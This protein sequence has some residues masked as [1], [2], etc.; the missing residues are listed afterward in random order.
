M[1]T[2][3]IKITFSL[4]ATS[5][6]LVVFLLIIAPE[7][8]GE[9]VSISGT[10]KNH[11]TKSAV[12][13]ALVSLVG[14]TLSTLTD[15]DG[16]FF[17]GT[18]VGV[19][20]RHLKR[21]STTVNS[22][23]GGIVFAVPS[24]AFISLSIFSFDG[25]H[26]FSM[27][28]SGLKTGSWVVSPSL[29]AGMYVCRAQVNRTIS[30]FKYFMKGAKSASFMWHINGYSTTMR[31][32][33]NDN[34]S[35][36]KTAVTPY[37]LLISKT[38]FVTRRDTLTGPVE[39][40][41]TIELDS[42][43]REPA[44]NFK[45]FNW[46]DPRNNFINGV[47]YISGLSSSSTYAQA[48]SLAEMVCGTWQNVGANTL[49]LPINVSTVASSFWNVYKG[50]VD[51]ATSMGFK[52]IL[53]PWAQSF[54]QKL[55]DQDQFFKMWNTVT[56]DYNK[57]SLVYFELMNE[58]SYSPASNW[59]TICKKWLNQFPTIP[60]GRVVIPGCG[61][62]G[63][64]NS[65]QMGEFHEFD[66][67]LLATHLYDPWDGS[68]TDTMFWYNLAES[69]IAPYADRTIVTEYGQSMSGN[70]YMGGPNYNAVEAYMAG[71]TR[72]MREHK[73]GGTSWPGLRDGDT[74]GFYKRNGTSSMTVTNE[75]GLA[76]IRYS[77][78]L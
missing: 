25:K 60:K 53:C 21:V 11:Q 29:A 10:V 41:L 69:Q 55:E 63:E 13:G 74:W 52:V 3:A 64:R 33:E 31:S 42:T 44:V 56:T 38:G 51:K 14:D 24:D 73:M 65:N 22:T 17:L 16:V 18:P 5:A 45:G 2:K 37:I 30:V 1:C 75:S 34:S 9:A 20:P 72:Y 12:Q 47:L 62:H 35:F 36:A 6:I 27:R 15:A 19:A 48:Q 7:V 54:T 76:R 59:A 23:A 40:G 67:C 70:D 26:S 68:T 61:E 58:V 43:S 39:T 50:V 49:R 28:K 4:S 32:P 78:G 8:R 77:W 66:S 57:N 46:A 71:F